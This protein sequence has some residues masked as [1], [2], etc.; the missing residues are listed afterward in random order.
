VM[1]FAS[2]C[3]VGRALAEDRLLATN[4]LYDDY[5]TQVRWRLLPG[6]W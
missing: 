3:N 2:S 6:V 4:E 1:I 5:C